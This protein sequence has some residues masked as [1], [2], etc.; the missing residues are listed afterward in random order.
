MLKKLGVLLLV[1]VFAGVMFAGDAVDV[2]EVGMSLFNLDTGGSDITTMS[3]SYAVEDGSFF[4][5]IPTGVALRLSAEKLAIFVGFLKKY[6]QWS[7]LAIKNGVTMNKT[8]G[9]LYDSLFWTYRGKWYGGDSG[10]KFQFF[11]GDFVPFMAVYGSNNVV[12]KVDS[13]VTRTMRPWLLTK[14]AVDDFLRVVDMDN[15]NAA[16]AKAKEQSAKEAMFK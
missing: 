4:L 5:N 9:N 11:S 16:L 12:S 13:Y 2:G 7:A 1:G 3:I 15:V 14:S 8:I 6:Q 10:F